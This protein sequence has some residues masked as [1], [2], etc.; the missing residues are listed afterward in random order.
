MRFG[1]PVSI[2]AM[3]PPGS[4]TS[5][6][7]NFS[8]LRGS[9]LGSSQTRMPGSASPII[10]PGLGQWAVTSRPSSSS[11]SARNRL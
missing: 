5:R 8:F 1:T 10:A 4:S 6:Q 2:P 9:S 7:P 3:C 11:T